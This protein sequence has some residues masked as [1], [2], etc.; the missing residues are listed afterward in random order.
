VVFEERPT[1]N[2]RVGEYK[3][4]SSHAAPPWYSGGTSGPS[5]AMLP[6]AN[7][8]RNPRVSRH[9]CYEVPPSAYGEG[10]EVVRWVKGPACSTS[11]EPLGDEG[12]RAA[13]VEVIYP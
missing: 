10:G 6:P 4:R 5:G 11:R 1:L 13:R 12:L 3:R 8:L 2:G 7:P 9:R